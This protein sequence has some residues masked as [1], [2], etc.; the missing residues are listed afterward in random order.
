MR[1]HIAI[2]LALLLLA[3]CAARDVG[4]K[5]APAVGTGQNVCPNGSFERLEGAARPLPQQ[6]S[7]YRQGPT[8][9]VEISDDACE[10]K[11]SLRLAARAGDIAGVNS[12]VM[13]LGHGLVRFRYKVLAS[14]ADGANLALYAIG[15]SGPDGGEVVRHGFSPPKEHVADGQWHEASF[16]FDFSDRRV[17][18]SLIAPRINENTAQAGDGDWLVDAIEVNAV[19]TGPRIRIANVWADK[20][21]ARTGD[22]ARFSAWVENDGDEEAAQVSLQLKASEGITCAAP[23]Q[24][25]RTLPAGSYERVDWELVAEKPAAAEIQVTAALK[26]DPAQT[27]HASYKMLVIDGKATYNRQELVT[28]EVGYWRLLLRPTTLQ[29][30]NNAPLAPIRHRR[31]SE[32]KRSSYGICAHLPRSRDYEAPFDP[33]HLIDDDPETCWSSQQNASP[34]PGRPPWVEIDLGR[35]VPIAQVNLIPYWRNTDFPAGF[36]V[37]ASVDG[38]SWR[39]VLEVKDHTLADS[40]ERRGDKLVQSFPLQGPAQAR[41]VRLDFERLPLSGGNYAEVS[42]GYKARLS[43]IEVIDDQGR[44]VAL[45]RLGAT[46]KVSDI[47]TGWQNTAKTVNESFSRIFDLGVKWVRVGQWGDQTECAAVEREKGKFRMDPATDAAIRELSENGVD[48]LWGLQYGN[49]LYDRP[50]NPVIDIGPIYKEGHPF[51]LNWGPRTAAGRRAFVR[52]VDYVVRKYKDRVKFWELW[53]EEN[54]WYPF[55]EPELY[56]KLL[57]AVAR[58]IKS[59]DRNLIVVFGGTAAP[60]P[61]TTEIALREG[62]AP[63]VDAYA[64][65]P[66]GIDKPEGG[67][68]TMEFYQG[69][70]LSQSREQTGWNRLED[71]LAGVR[72]PFARHGKPS[73]DVWLNEWSTN[74]AGLDYSYQPGI[75]EYGCAKYLIRFYIY[76]GWLGL[77]TAWWALYNENLSQDWGVIDPR[78]YGFRPLS[79]A[80]QNVCSVVSDVTP[81]RDLNYAY[82]G[83][84]PDLKVIAHRRDGGD[85]MLVLAWA[86]ELFDEQVKA[87]PSRLSFALKSRPRRVTLSDLYWGVSQPAVWSYGNG[88]LTLDGLIVRDYPV[89]IACR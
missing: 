28:D 40:G 14:S 3:I 35:A 87:Y 5:A 20:P 29:E 82:E 44:N 21:L 78:D 19:R 38:R 72:R 22:T 24:N 88:M 51:Y 45:K 77:R 71:I 32:I 39:T 4:V 37:R 75:G 81:I 26:G 65:H 80:L 63:Y 57:L 9:R 34:Y 31:S 12:A 55:H 7:E 61:I 10:G 18:H 1:L 8:A 25:V 73:V 50:E 46:V 30:G 74:V 86:A 62:A 2:A 54:G 6:W 27:Q 33:S 83:A 84:A 17:K 47:F 48:I 67:M 59:I 68:G 42:Q 70:D 85:E 41:N 43:G 16:E 89:V 52:Y 13:G 49:A 76:S 64:F 58:R 36:T 66:Y 56:G 79:Y 23:V 60:T 53:N 15:L 11:R 69:Q